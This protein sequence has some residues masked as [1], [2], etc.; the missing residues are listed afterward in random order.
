MSTRSESNEWEVY[1]KESFDR[2]GDDLCE[3]LLSY[4][5]FEDRF[6]Y[7][8]LSKQFQR[9][10]FTTVSEITIHWKFGFISYEESYEKSYES[11]LKK[12]KNVTRIEYISYEIPIHY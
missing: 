12:C 9:F 6:R 4:L 11:I 8:C 3:V 10:I 2:F 1:P 7:E 5:S